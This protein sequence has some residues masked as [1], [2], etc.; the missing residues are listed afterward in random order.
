MFGREGR[1]VIG[2][3]LANCSNTSILKH[4]NKNES[5]YNRMGKHH[6]GPVKVKCKFGLFGDRHCVG[7]ESIV[8]MLNVVKRNSDFFDMFNIICGERNFG[9]GSVPRHVV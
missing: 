1:S 7:G 2:Y 3:L 8:C 4:P 6:G 5:W 9:E